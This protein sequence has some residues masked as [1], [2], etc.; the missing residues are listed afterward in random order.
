VIAPPAATPEEEATM[1]RRKR[2]VKK[3]APPKP[4]AKAKPV[5][6][7]GGVAAFARGFVRDLPAAAMS[8]VYPASSSDRFAGKTFDIADGRHDSD[9]W[10][11][12][13]RAG[14]FVQAIRADCAGAFKD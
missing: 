2:K 4:A 10:Q 11:F 13:F 6:L 5:P 8:G 7:A 1:A 9:G 12:E 3:P 14:V